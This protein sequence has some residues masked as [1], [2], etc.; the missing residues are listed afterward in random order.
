MSMLPVPQYQDWAAVL[1]LYRLSSASVNSRLH[2]GVL[3]TAAL[4]PTMYV[5]SNIKYKD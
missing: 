5:A 1:D 2:S 3:S 4:R